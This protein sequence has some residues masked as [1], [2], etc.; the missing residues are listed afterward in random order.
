[1]TGLALSEL[2][3]SRF[4]LLGAAHFGVVDRDDHVAFAD[5]RARRRTPFAVLDPHARS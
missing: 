2:G 3:D 1:L 5:A 4:E